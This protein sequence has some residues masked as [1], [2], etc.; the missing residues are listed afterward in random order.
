MRAT[1][2]V[3]AFGLLACL[4][5]G[6]TP[7]ADPSEGTTTEPRSGSTTSDQ[8]DADAAEVDP[9]TPLGWGPTVGDLEQAQ[10]IV[11]AMSSEEL[12]GQVI[13]GRY[14]GND[15]A[16]VAAMLLEHHLAGIS[17]TNGNVV[18]EAQVRAMTAALMQASLDDGRDFPPV[19]GVDQEGGY[20]SHLRGIATEFPAFDAAGAAI[21]SQGA[22]GREV[23]RQA[24]YATGLELRELGFTW[25]F[26]P[27]ADVTIGA[28]DPTIGTRSASK[29][30]A[31]AA[32]A[33][34]AA[35]RGFD[36]AGVVSTVKHF[37][38]HG[39]ATSDSHDTLPALDSSLAQLQEHDLPPFEAAIATH[40]PAVMLAHL[41]LS[42]IAPG[43]PSSLAPEV[44][45]LLREDLGFEGVAITDSLGMGAVAATFKPAVAAL[46]AGA[47][48]LLMPVDT[49]E[50]HRVVT[51]AIDDG[52]V[53]RERAEEAA[54]RVVALQ[55]WQQRAA[56]ATPVPADVAS[57]AQEAAAALTAAAY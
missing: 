57:L 2:A 32:E 22:T 20:V 26:A 43:V 31:I 15:P 46:N 13:V 12:A 39:A 6:C 34:A 8:P 9:S 25:V 30:P 45:E 7:Q 11:A 36:A 16:E 48:L 37:P 29:D 24:S 18:D 4:F 10:E 44:Y 53:S 3:A 55:L 17:V 38:G 28:A 51:K 27:V 54:A 49:A 47:D 56:A 41:D 50:T 40:A 21:E 5:A 52:E 19:L 1:R 42:A 14:L 35:V 23:V 33:T